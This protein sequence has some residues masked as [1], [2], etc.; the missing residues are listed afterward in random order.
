[1]TYAGSVRVLVVH[2]MI[3]S[4]PED[5]SFSASSTEP[6][7]KHLNGENSFVALVSPVAMV[8]ACD[9]DTC[10]KVNKVNTNSAKQ[11]NYELRRQG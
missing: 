6:G 7:K 2:A 3:A 4:P 8:A 9:S 1:M 11:W 10:S 5:R